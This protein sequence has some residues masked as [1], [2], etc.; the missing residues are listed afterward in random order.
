MNKKILI[1][2]VGVLVLAG[3]GGGVYFAIKGQ[4]M[5]NTSALLTTGGE[6][7]DQIL[8]TYKDANLGFR[9]EYPN[10]LEV[11]PYEDDKVNYA[12]I[13][14]TSPGSEGN[15]I[16]WAKDTT[17]TDLSEW[18]Q[19]EEEVAGGNVL[20]TTWGGKEAKK[21]RI[22]KPSAKVVTATLYDDLLFLIE[23]TPDKDGKLD[24][25]YE[26]ILSSFKFYTVSEKGETIPAP[27]TSTEGGSSDES[28]DVGDEGVLEEDGGY[29]DEEVVE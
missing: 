4:K 11:N 1:A 14:L 7:R 8:A 9:F 27:D 2:V 23:E 24:T 28:T 6:N 21:V 25:A 17:Y 18:L 12:H 26:N 15:I 22:S 19:G 29:V 3:M 16:I 20:D 13:E 10:N 5:K